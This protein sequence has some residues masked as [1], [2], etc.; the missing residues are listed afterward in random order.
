VG[1]ANPLVDFGMSWLKRQQQSEQS[2][3]AAGILAGKITTMG[4]R[5]AAGDRQAE[6][7]TAGILGPVMIKSDQSLKDPFS[8]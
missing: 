2:P 1:E 6:A 4:S 5:I 7:R 8:L 3:H